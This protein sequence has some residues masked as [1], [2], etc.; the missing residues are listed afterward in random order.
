MAFARL[1]FIVYLPHFGLS[2]GVLFVPLL[3][4][5]VMKVTIGT[6]AFRGFGQ[7]ACPIVGVQMMGL[8]AP[9]NKQRGIHGCDYVARR[10]ITLMVIATVHVS[11]IIA[12]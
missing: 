3:L 11:A 6:P 12:F 4:R 8:P 7:R 5:A 9:R 1:E 2:F 10:F